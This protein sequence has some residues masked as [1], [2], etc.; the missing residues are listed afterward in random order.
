MIDRELDDRPDDDAYDSL[1]APLAYFYCSRNR[2]EPERAD[3]DEILR[4]IARQLC[5]DKPELP[6]CEAL[7]HLYGKM[8]KPP[9]G[10]KR[11]P[12][13]LTVGLIMKV[14]QDNPATIVIDALDECDVATRYRLFEVL[15][16]LVTKSSNIVKV[17]LTSRNDGDIVCRLSTTPNIYIDA[18]K[19]RA[20]IARF[21]HGEVQNAISKG[22]M[23]NG[24]VS[25]GLRTRILFTLDQR[26]HGT[27]VTSLCWRDFWK[28]VFAYIVFRFRWVS[29]QVQNLCDPQRMR[30]EDD[31]QRELDQLPETLGRLYELAFSQILGL[32]PGLYSMAIKAFVLV[33]VAIRPISWPEML[34]ML[35]NSSGSVSKSQLLQI[36]SNFLEDSQEEDRP[37]L[38]HSSAREYLES[39]PELR[40]DQANV[41][42]SLMCLDSI[43]VCRKEIPDVVG[44]GNEELLAYPFFYL[45]PH[46]A[47]TTSKAREPY[48]QRYDQL[49]ISLP[50]P[51]GAD[52]CTELFR[53]WR[54]GAIYLH[55]EGFLHLNRVDTA[56]MCRRTLISATPLIT[57][58]ATGLYEYLRRLMPDGGSGSLYNSLEFHW[59][60]LSW[61]GHQAI[62]WLRGKNCLEMTVILREHNIIREF[63]AIGVDL[64]RPGA[65]GETALHLAAKLEESS[66]METLLACG[67][68]PNSLSGTSETNPD[69]LDDDNLPNASHHRQETEGRYSTM[70]MGE[71][72]K[73]PMRNMLAVG[74]P[75]TSM[76]F[77]TFHGGKSGVTSPFALKQERCAPIHLAVANS[78]GGLA[79]VETLIRFG[80]D[81][82][83]RTSGGNTPLQLSLD[84]GKATPSIVRALL[85]GGAH[86]NATLDHGQTLLH[87]AAA[88]GAHE[89]VQAVVEFGGD[90][91]FRDA[92]N[93]TPFELAVRLGHWEVAKIL[94]PDGA[95]AAMAE[96]EAKLQGQPL[97]RKQPGRRNALKQGDNVPIFTLT[98]VDATAVQIS[99]GKLA[100]LSNIIPPTF[101]VSMGKLWHGNILAVEH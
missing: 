25:D 98:T 49:L 40:S 33:L 10:Q 15:D 79:C 80:A 93:R 43:Q 81:V 38:A 94:S 85:R 67:A 54:K 42:M 6:I 3:T 45:A 7:K 87:L 95:R 29:L 2:A 82:N 100:T 26:A 65:E 88:A 68:D 50:G 41:T 8:G 47:G 22:L 97:A 61:T 19:N 5:R 66:V 60:L 73:E 89:V 69:H 63:A 99:D 86:V 58:C 12:L 31:I 46:L 27:Y 30:T 17:F 18:H 32:P 75:A 44:K 71:F 20:D 35:S 72:P 77:R 14:L 55:D 37:R 74:R 76:G 92:L 4:C 9:A 11:P 84:S 83:M 16:A 53:I 70:L 96:A 52:K 21:V 39:L 90:P 13:D 51:W 57:V 34:F 28:T 48:Q 24:N 78:N 36:T 64:N 1:S 56:T 59:P 23:L 91:F 62:N 101:V